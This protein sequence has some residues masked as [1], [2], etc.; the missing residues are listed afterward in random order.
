M[1]KKVNEERGAKRLFIYIK[2]IREKAEE[3]FKDSGVN[4]KSSDRGGFPRN[5]KSPV[6]QNLFT[7]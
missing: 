7:L 4:K 5:K 3:N 2:K 1:L 6:K